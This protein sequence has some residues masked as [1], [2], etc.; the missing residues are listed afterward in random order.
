M[1]ISIRSMHMS[2]TVTFTASCNRS[3]SSTHILADL[4]TGTEK[5][6]SR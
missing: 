6:V 4:S 3:L 2:K 1:T 5:A